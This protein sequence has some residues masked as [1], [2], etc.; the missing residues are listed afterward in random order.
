VVSLGPYPPAELEAMWADSRARYERDLLDN[1][2]LTAAE[3]HAKAERDG[4]WLR[5]LDTVVLEIEHEG[6][7]VGRVVL[8]LDAFEKPG[9]AWLFEIV[10]DEEVRGRGLGREALRLAEAEARS[11]GMRRIE[12]NVFGGNEVARSLYLSAGYAETSVRMAKPL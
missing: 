7:R 10:L 3:S 8:W 1:G 9:Q 11:R 2:G 6:A 12:L 5:T 4:E